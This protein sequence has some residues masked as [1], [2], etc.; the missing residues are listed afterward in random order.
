MRQ[1]TGSPIDAPSSTVS[2]S[3]VATQPRVIG[4]LAPRDVVSR[5]IVSEMRMQHASHL[6]LD[7]SH[8]AADWLRKRFPGIYE[9]CAKRGLDITRD[10]LP[11]VPAAHYFCGGVST[12]LVGRTTVPGLFAAGAMTDNRTC[13]EVDSGCLVS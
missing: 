8:R 3:A 12:D 4:Q 11:V 10:P 6:Y 9:H 7:I 2:S 13:S 1:S 5:M